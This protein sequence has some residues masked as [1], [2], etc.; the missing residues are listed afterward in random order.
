M[1][2][3]QVTA[4]FQEQIPMESSAFTLDVHAARCSGHNYPAICG[5]D[6]ASNVIF[7][8]HYIP[9]GIFICGFLIR[10][11]DS[12]LFFSIWRKLSYRKVK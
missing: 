8:I 2:G 11:L 9:G 1:L 5:G 3:L 6:K 10:V 12:N 4:V 7:R